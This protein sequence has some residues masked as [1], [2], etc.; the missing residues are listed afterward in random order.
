MFVFVCCGC[1]VSVSVSGSVFV[2]VF[3]LCVVCCVLCL[4]C[5]LCC[6]CVMYLCLVCLCV[7]VCRCCVVCVGVC[8]C[9]VCVAVCVCLCVCGCC[10]YEVYF[11]GCT[12]GH[13]LLPV[14]FHLVGGLPF[15]FGHV[16]F[17]LEGRF[18]FSIWSVRVNT[19]KTGLVVSNVVWQGGTRHPLSFNSALYTHLT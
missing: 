8:V 16:I 12:S 2:V 10:V 4:C 9:C 14:I 18:A 19:H 1:V 3:V 13:F 7:C 15:P 17:H 6:V 5:A 11:G